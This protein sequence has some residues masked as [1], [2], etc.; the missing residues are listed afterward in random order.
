MRAPYKPRT[1]VATIASCEFPVSAITHLRT[2]SI[3]H[4][5][6]HLA[7]GLLRPTTKQRQQQ[8]QQQHQTNNDN[9]NIKHGRVA[10]DVATRASRG[11]Y[12]SHPRSCGVRICE[13]AC[14]LLQCVMQ[15]SCSW[16]LLYMCYIL[17][18]SNTVARVCVVVTHNFPYLRFARAAVAVFLLCVCIN[19]F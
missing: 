8:Q 1:L 2:G 10:A 12:S 17:Q 19:D 11:G 5:V 4:N 3:S 18:R 16:E 13:F 14:V 7:A 9:N 15:A 6:L